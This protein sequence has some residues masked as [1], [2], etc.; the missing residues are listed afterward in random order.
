[1][2][3]KVIWPDQTTTSLPVPEVMTGM[4]AVADCWGVPPAAAGAAGAVVAA[5]AAAGAAGLVSAGFESAGLA[6]AAAGA[7]PDWPQAATIGAISVRPAPRP[8]VR[9][10]WRRPSFLVSMVPPLGCGIDVDAIVSQR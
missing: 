6:G 8:S 5:G 2:S 1:M 3:L 10:T 7:L 4:A 9:M